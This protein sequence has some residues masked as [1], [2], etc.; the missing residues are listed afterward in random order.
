MMHR[1]VLDSLWIA[2][3]L[4][5]AALVTLAYG[6]GGF[7]DYPKTDVATGYEVVEG[8]PQ[9]PAEAEWGAMP[10]VTI[11]PSGNVWSFNRGNIPIQIYTPDGTL[12]GSWGQDGVFA[13]PHQIRFDPEG[14]LWAVDNGAHT[15]TKF[16]PDGEAL[17][18]LGT[19][20]EPGEDPTH[21]NQPTDVAVTPAGDIFVSD[22][23]VNSRVVHFDKTGTFVKAWGKLGTDPGEFSLAHGIGVDS[24]GRLYVVD[25][26][27]ARI[28]VFEQSGEYIT[29][30]RNII[31]PWAIWITPQDEV[32][33]CG[34]SPSQW[35]ETPARG[36]QMNGIPPK[37]QIVV[38]FDTDG[39]VGQIWAFPQGT[40]AAGEISWV[41]GMAVSANGDLYLGDIQGRRVQ[42]FARRRGMN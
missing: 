22:G 24:N 34:S 36:V 10:G 18:T 9:K 31:T 16:T 4:V 29:E 26:N 35:R 28:Q 3:V 17:L 14:N 20:N 30:W 8:W 15:V 42:K 23:Y 21:F 37:D 40:T 25:R 33:V 38:K 5:I 2:G 19:P 1:H 7:P 6:Q 27:N 39:R 13:N 41:H 12:V 32:Y 11:G